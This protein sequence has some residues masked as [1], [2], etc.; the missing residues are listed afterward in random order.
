MRNYVYVDNSNLFI[1]GQRVSAVRRGLARNIFE[2]MNNGILDFEWNLDYGRLYEMVCGDKADVAGARLWGSPPPGDSFWGMVKRKGWDV[3][4]YDRNVA[5]KEK[6][7]DTAITYR[8][9]KD[10]YT[11]VDRKMSEL[12]LVAGDKDYAPAVEDLVKEGFRLTVAFWGQAA[13]ELR[14]VASEFFELD[15]FVDIVGRRR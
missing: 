10:A 4:I 3:Q 8:M 6:K 15:R 1:E 5:G 13:K 2:A 7:V 14:D 12:T 11:V 9:A